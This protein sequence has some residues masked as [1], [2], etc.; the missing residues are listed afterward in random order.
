LAEAAR[1][2]DLVVVGARGRGVIAAEL[3]GSVSTWLLQE[4][5]VPVAV[6][7]DGRR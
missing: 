3:L 1:S 4:A 2:A 5:L 6:V 7:P